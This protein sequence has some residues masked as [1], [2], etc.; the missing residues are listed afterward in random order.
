MN[1]VLKWQKLEWEVEVQ[2]NQSLILVICSTYVPQSVKG[3]YLEAEQIGVFWTLARKHADR[4]NY[5][6]DL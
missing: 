4:S 2:V 3:C 6:S 5:S 1:R